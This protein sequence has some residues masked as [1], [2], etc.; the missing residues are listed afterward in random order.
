MRT[1]LS[2]GKQMSFL[3]F[4]LSATT[5]FADEGAGGC[6]IVIVTVL[7]RY[8]CG[9]GGQDADHGLGGAGYLRLRA[10]DIAERGV[11]DSSGVSEQDAV[12]PP[13]T[14]H[15]VGGGRRRWCWP[16][17][18]S[19]QLSLGAGVAIGDVVG[20]RRDGEG[21][22]ALAASGC[23][24]EAAGSLS[25]TVITSRMTRRTR[26]MITAVSRAAAWVASSARPGRHRNRVPRTRPG[27][28]LGRGACRRHPRRAHIAGPGH[29]AARRRWRRKNSRRL[30]E[31]SATRHPTDLQRTRRQKKCQIPIPGFPAPFGPR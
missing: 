6:R 25:R 29:G 12:V 3:S 5:A 30:N 20:A 22:A 8:L 9:T 26:G 19:I 17:S 15:R 24:T 21:G 1:T 18:T 2:P 31:K 7:S 23:A 10:G 14:G 16:R 13:G 11:G 27:V 28:H 4:V